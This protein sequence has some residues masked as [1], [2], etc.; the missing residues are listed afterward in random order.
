LSILRELKQSKPFPSPGQ[1]AAVALLHTADVVR[2]VIGAVVEPHGITAQQYNVLRILRG[3]GSDGLPTLEIASR[4]V[5]R[6]PGI[7]R[8][9]E[10][11]QAKQLLKR[12][13]SSEDR[14][15]VYCYITP[16]GMALLATLDGP[17]RA[18]TDST[19]LAVNKKELSQLVQSLDKL[20]Q[21]LKTK[22]KNS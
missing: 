1:E 10:R 11:L 3:A 14:R 16:A 22:E 19:F 12:E 9:V 4:M 8:L 15:H 20:R 6:T 5:E 21:G 13:R 18:A 2:R 17:L 7:T